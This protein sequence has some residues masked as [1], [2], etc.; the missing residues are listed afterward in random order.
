MH[1]LSKPEWVAIAA[2]RLHHRWRS[3]N[4]SQLG[5]VVAELW[6]DAALREL[7]PVP[8]VEAWLT[9][10]LALDPPARPCCAAVRRQPPDPPDPPDPAGTPGR[11]GA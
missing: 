7:E 4:P 1:H 5:E 6:K 9:P 10:I 8:A 3:I 11:T 2:H